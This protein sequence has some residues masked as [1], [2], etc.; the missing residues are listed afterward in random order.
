MS[1]HKPLVQIIQDNT[2]KVEFPAPS[3]CQGYLL[4]CEFLEDMGLIHTD[5]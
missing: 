4:E 2:G 5:H 1:I 3:K